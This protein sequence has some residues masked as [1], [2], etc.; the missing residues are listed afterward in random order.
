MHQELI[1]AKGSIFVESMPKAYHI[2]IEGRFEYKN[3]TTQY[4][5][6]ASTTPHQLV[7]RQPPKIQKTQHERT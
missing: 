1:K 6:R 2:F 7:R 5:Q 4:E 3:A